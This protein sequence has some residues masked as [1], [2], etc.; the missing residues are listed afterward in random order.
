MLGLQLILGNVAC[1][2]LAD[3]RW[4]CLKGV[5]H[6]ASGREAARLFAQKEGK[7]PGT[8]RV[9]FMGSPIPIQFVHLSYLSFLSKASKP[10]KRSALRSVQCSNPTLT[11]TNLVSTVASLIALHSIKLSTPP[12]L[13]A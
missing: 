8:R 9:F 10:L 4:Y 3:Y 2:L 6:M 13:V 12:K 1:M 11:L 7:L 5:I